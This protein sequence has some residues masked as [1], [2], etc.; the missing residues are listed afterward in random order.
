M[1]RRINEDAGEE[2]KTVK[3]KLIDTGPPPD[4]EKR[5]LIFDSL[6]K[7]IGKNF[8]RGGRSG[9]RDT[10]GTYVYT[11]GA[12]YQG[13]LGRV[14]NRGKK[15]YATVPRR[16]EGM[17]V[18]VRQVAC[19][20]IH[21][22]VVTDTGTVYTWGDARN[23]QLGYQPQGFTNQSTPKEVEKLSEMGVFIVKVACGQVH[24]VALTDR[25]VLLSWGRSKWGQLGHGNRDKCQEPKEVNT[26]DISP[27]LKFV[28][29]S[30]GDRHTAALSDKGE[31]Y[32]FGNGEHGQLGHGPKT[33][34]M[35]ST[36]TLVKSLDGINIVSV[37]CGSLHSCFIS[38]HGDLYVCGFGENFY[39][40]EGE[41][42]FYEPTK[43]PFKDKGKVVQVASGQSHIVALNN[44]GEVYCWG[45]GLYGQLGH[46][47]KGN[48]SLPRLVLTGKS[49]AQVA[50]GRYHSLA[51][52]TFGVI[53]SWG[54]GENG[55]LG[56]RDDNPKY[57]PQVIEPN[58]VVGQIACGEHHTAV[59]TST[60][61][62]RVHSEVAEWLACE[63]EEHEKKKALL[64]KKNQGL[65][66]KDLLKIQE[67]MN[68]VKKRKLE[69]KKV[70]KVK[71]DR[72][73]RDYIAG[74][75]N[76]DQIESEL[77]STAKSNRGD[78]DG[79]R[80][81]MDE[82]YDG[83]LQL[84]SSENKDELKSKAQKKPGAK[85]STRKKQMAAPVHSQ[86][87]DLEST[88]VQKSGAMTERAATAGMG[89]RAQFL[90]KST[91]MV[92]LFK[93]IISKTGDS[94]NEA[95]L[96]R[97]IAHT[98]D[99]RKE[100][101]AL[102]AITNQKSKI[103][104]ESK[105]SMKALKSNNL[106]V[107]DRKK[108]YS[109]RVKT[110]E[111]KLNTVTIKILETEENRKNYDLNISH[112]KDEDMERYNQLKEMRSHSAAYDA[113][114]KKFN[115]M[116]LH[117]QEEK[118]R[119]EAE[120]ALFEMEIEQFK[121]FISDQL[122]KFQSISSVSRQRR[123]RR[124]K[125]RE[126]RMQKTQE[127][128][129][130][131]ISKLNN[132]LEEKEREALQMAQ[133]LESV[134][135]RLRYFEKRFQQIASATGLTDP[136][137]I[138]N[139]YA[140]KE[141][142]KTELN[143]DIAGKEHE[144]SRLQNRLAKLKQECDNLAANFVDST[145]TDIHELQSDLTMDDSKA[146]QY[147]KEA[148]GLEQTLAYFQEGLFNLSNRIPLEFGSSSVQE[149][150]E[151]DGQNFD[152]K[153]TLD[154][155]GN[156]AERLDVMAIQVEEQQARLDEERAGVLEAQKQEQELA[157]KLQSSNVDFAGV[158]RS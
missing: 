131:R 2:E 97:I 79:V 126:T 3:T 44:R 51:L 150:A 19:G 15:R 137:A 7:I 130:G 83:T 54:C 1:P 58:T 48:L 41:N 95:N 140:L 157:E 82:G 87:P 105:Q 72:E 89:Q 134:N 123:V 61:W 151:S 112:L 103:L 98:F 153:A 68:A 31:V 92:E 22:A 104:A 38:D 6:S 88:Q 29:I 40:N 13:Q 30:C 128:I 71:E 129:T 64:K 60:P 115:E 9:A 76:R 32:T 8:E 144:I 139:K 121:S 133:Q 24:T 132:E 17:E 100:Y 152:K 113:L 4:F 20:G 16:V 21:T 53:Y 143:M 155:L 37:D 119:A 78:R 50:A 141:E 25:G 63:Q 114:W 74:V 27:S 14:F 158:F 80:D 34:K 73:N 81:T 5:E 90:K 110:L 136:D 124:E 109:S 39:P 117:S 122:A 65:F 52:T 149:P 142:I 101:D 146:Q 42:F 145:W 35:V 26:K 156:L 11:W 84:P 56:H 118:E 107:R 18:A 85:T 106:A 102:K 36:P 120:L 46:G 43:I 147:Q 23:Y 33:E 47:V 135:E 62:N 154:C 99:V 45:S 69:E 70:S 10:R 91:D 55:Q 86:T 111:M 96:K 67:E 116:K 138:I 49:I 127:K 94:S 75:L 93:D 148:E 77:R 28:D 57:F 59:L 12:G 108:A 125:Q 66:K